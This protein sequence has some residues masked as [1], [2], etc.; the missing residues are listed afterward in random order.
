MRRRVRARD[1]GKSLAI[2]ADAR[3]TGI[4]QIL[5]RQHGKPR[6]HR[7]NRHLAIARMPKPKRIA[8]VS[9]QKIE[10]PVSTRVKMRKRI[11]RRQG[12]GMIQ[13]KKGQFAAAAFTGG[14]AK[15]AFAVKN[16]R[17]NPMRVDGKPAAPR[18]R[19][20]P[21]HNIR[22]FRPMCP[23]FRPGAIKPFVTIA[24]KDHRP[25]GQRVKKNHHA[26]HLTCIVGALFSGAIKKE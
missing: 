16:R 19:I 3:L 25:V 9:E 13:G 26:A 8:V 14:G 21:A 6:R 22:L 20:P 18:K 1:F 10:R 24:G 4:V 7:R 23:G 17:Q 11:R 15:A 12:I 5:A 2:V